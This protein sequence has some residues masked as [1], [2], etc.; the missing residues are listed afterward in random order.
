MFRYQQSQQ[1]SGPAQSVHMAGRHR[2]WPAGREEPL[3]QDQT[4]AGA[5]QVSSGPGA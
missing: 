5:G 2:D 4:A 1:W 3:Q